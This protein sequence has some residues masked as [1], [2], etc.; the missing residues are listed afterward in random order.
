M[1]LSSD[2]VTLDNSVTSDPSSTSNGQ[3]WYNSTTG[4]VRAQENGIVGDLGVLS[5]APVT[6]TGT[7]TTASATP[8]LVTNMTVTPTAGTYLV[9][10]HGAGYIATTGS[11]HYIEVSIF[12]NNV[13][14]AESRQQLADGPNFTTPFNTCCVATVNGSQTIAGYWMVTSGSGTASML[15]T[16]TLSLIKIG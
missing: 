1:P 8:V 2:I 15:G 4:T 10:F 3:I 16:R 6:A 14:A 7:I 12:T 11:G 13:Q 5:V 9:F